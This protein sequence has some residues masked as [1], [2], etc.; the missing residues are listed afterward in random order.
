MIL[1]AVLAFQ[2]ATAKQPEPTLSKRV[3][4]APVVQPIEAGTLS[5]LADKLSP[6]W[7]LDRIMKLDAKFVQTHRPKVS[8][9]VSP[10]DRQGFDASVRVTFKL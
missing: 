3:L 5:K 7:E 2:I 8:L 4:E 9:H 1:E 6:S 10:G